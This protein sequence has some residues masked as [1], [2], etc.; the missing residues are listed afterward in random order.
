[1]NRLETQLA[2]LVEQ[3]VLSAAQAHGA[4][5]GGTGR[6]V[7]PAVG[8]GRAGIRTKPQ[9]ALPFWR[10]WVMSEGPWCWVR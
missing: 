5:G 9:R 7:G 4:G 8:A 2:R 10:S 1:M 6:R 3:Q